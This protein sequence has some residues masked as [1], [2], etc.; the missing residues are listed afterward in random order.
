MGKNTNLTLQ[1]KY[2][3]QFGH[4]CEVYRH[5]NYYDLK[6]VRR[7]GTDRAV[8]VHHIFRMGGR[9]DLW[10]NLIAVNTVI[11]KNWGHDANE[12]ILK[13]LCLYSK[14]VKS[15]QE[16]SAQNPFPER[17]FNID[18]LNEAAGKRVQGLIQIFMQGFTEGTDYWQM[19]KLMTES[20]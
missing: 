2:R 19:C 12:P 16:A 7:L 14:F 1:I 4:E 15:Q 20:F 17:E 6:E 8:E 3:K 13:T 11:H 18:E 9:H 10:S 5:M